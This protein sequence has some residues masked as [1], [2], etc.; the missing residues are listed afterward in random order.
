MLL[1]NSWQRI[2][3]KSRNNYQKDFVKGVK[4]L[5]IS[6]LTTLSSTAQ[7]G[8]E[9]YRPA[10]HY[11]PR[12]NWMSDPNGLVY[13]NGKYHLFYQY[14]PQGNQPGNQSWGHAISTDLIN[15][16][17]KSVAIPVQN[18][19]K[20]FSGSVVVD[21]NNTSGF[22][23]NG[24]PPLVAIYTGSSNVQDQRLAYSNDEGLTWTNYTQNPVISS[25]TN[26]F[27]DPKVIWHQETQKWI[28]VVSTGFNLKVNFY[29]SPDL[30][31]WTPLQDFGVVENLSEFWECPEFFKLNVDND[32]S[33]PK[34][35][36]AHSLP[37]KHVGQYFIGDFDGQHFNWTSVA[38]AGTLIDDFESGNYNRWSISGNAFG[39][40]PASGNLSTQRIVS[41]YLGNKLINSFFDGN[42][43]QGKM[44]SSNFTIQKK[45]IS[46][47]IGG[48][49]FPTGTYIKLVIDG[50]TIKTGTGQN[51]DFLTWTNWD[52][53]NLIGRTAHIEIV[54]SMTTDRGH[55]T[56]DHIIQSDVMVHKINTGQLDHGRDFYAAQSFSDIPTTDGR[57]IWMGWLNNWEYAIQIPT[58]PWKGVMSI[59]REVRLETIN[60]QVKLVQKPIKELEALRKDRLSF[61]NAKIDV[62]NSA[63]NDSSIIGMIDNST[64]KRFELKARI[65][66]RDKKGFSLKFKMQGTQYSEYVFDFINKEIRFDRSNSGGLSGW[67]GFR[68]LQVAPLLTTNGIFDLHLFVDNSSA[69]LFSGA[70]QV[71]MSNQIFPD[72]TSNMIGFSSLEGDLF[73][74]ELD[75]WS[76]E[77]NSLVPILN[78]EKNPLFRVYPNPVDVN[79]GLHLKI[80]DQFVGEVTF[81]LFDV[82]GKRL[83]EF[84]PASSSTIISINHLVNS[85]GIYFLKG[86][87]GQISQTEKLL[88]LRN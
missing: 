77:K 1:I 38:P 26:Q 65:S 79:N 64:Y 48:G 6:F 21:W 57:R 60:G 14:N 36:L 82:A 76:F 5:I 46:F 45:F 52:V 11:S 4:L 49:N 42:I 85:K 78:P 7:L 31:S 41:G 24:K 62:I 22:G 71:V 32:A 88:L 59:P 34:W 44:V 70:G 3:I 54:D 86:T 30:K 20:A 87:N 56:V 55:I 35:V 68:Q 12:Q 9:L 18:G 51:D 75:I 83:M 84:Q 72:S 58:S 50:N 39:S 28:M 16:E 40:S 15:W 27:R 37:S 8:N 17:E 66:V 29:N 61:R 25:T 67:P 53:S 10:Y 33:K 2:L 81:I 74:D 19:I 63:I 73:F 80:Q 13:Y 43:S 47:L 23:I 69:E